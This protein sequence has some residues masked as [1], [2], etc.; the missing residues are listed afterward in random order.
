MLFDSIH[1]RLERIEGKI[2]DHAKTTNG[3]PR[4]RYKGLTTTEW[5]IAILLAAVVGADLVI[6]VVSG[7][8]PTLGGG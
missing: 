2:D 3:H 6:D 1:E 8:L 7:L 5:L 4:R